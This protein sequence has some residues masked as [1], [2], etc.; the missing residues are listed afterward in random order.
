MEFDR[1]AEFEKVINLK[2]CETLLAQFNCDQVL[3]ANHRR[4]ESNGPV[5]RWNVQVCLYVTSKLFL[6]L[7]DPNYFTNRHF[8]TRFA[9]RDW[10]ELAAS[11]DS[12]LGKFFGL[13]SPLAK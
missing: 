8:V 7:P 2:V 3:T 6:K 5:T 1:F 4:I 13:F 9:E 12:L 10:S 11:V